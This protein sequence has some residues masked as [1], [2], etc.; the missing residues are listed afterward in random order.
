MSHAATN[1]ANS[2]NSG[3]V[4]GWTTKDVRYSA[5]ESYYN[6]LPK[7]KTFCKLIIN[8][9]SLSLSLSLSFFTYSNFPTL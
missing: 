6:T 9:N 8:G 3:L 7:M 1:P 5:K 4:R 2:Q